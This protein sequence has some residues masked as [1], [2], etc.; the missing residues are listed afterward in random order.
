M[1]AVTL[2]ELEAA[3]L[4]VDDLEDIVNGASDLN[5]TGLVGTRT[6]GDKKTLSKI[7][8]EIAETGV[9]P[10]PSWSALA[11]RVPGL[12]YGVADIPK[13]VVGTHTD[14]VV[15]GTVD[16]A[17]RYYWS[18][19]PA[20]WERIGDAPLSAS[21]VSA[22]EADV[23]AVELSL[24]A[25]GAGTKAFLMAHNC[26]IIECAADGTVG[27]FR[28]VR[29][30]TQNRGA[31]VHPVYQGDLTY[32]EDVTD[33]DTGVSISTSPVYGEIWLRMGQSLADGQNGNAGA[34]QV[35]NGV[36]PEPLH[37]FMPA[38]GIRVE[39]ST[40][41]TTVAAMLETSVSNLGETGLTSFADHRIS[42]VYAETGIKPFIYGAVSANG[43]E[44]GL[45]LVRGTDDYTWAMNAIAD[46]AAVI[47]KDGRRPIVKGILWNH[48]HSEQAKFTSW[49]LYF[50]FLRTLIMQ[51]N[52]DVQLMLPG[53][54]PVRLYW[55]PPDAGVLGNPHGTTRQIDIVQAF[56][57]ASLRCDLIRLTGPIHQFERT[58]DE[59]HCT[60]KGYTL[61]GQMEARATV[62]DDSGGHVPVQW[63][64]E[65]CRWVGAGGTTLRMRFHIKN[66]PISLGA[67]GDVT[68]T[69]L[70]TLGY[71]FWDTTNSSTITPS[72]VSVVTPAAGAAYA[73]EIDIEF[74]TSMVG[75]AGF[76]MYGM[77]MDAGA[78]DHNNGPEFG[79]R[80]PIRDSLGEAGLAVGVGYD[81]DDLTIHLDYNFA[82]SEFMYVGAPV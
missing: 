19:S 40:R 31:T 9:T 66:R 82:I 64:R 3:K 76:I 18:V 65:Q 23:A 34:D 16:D 45:N 73:D 8:E 70:S 42:K 41:F 33:A 39:S 30:A 13:S 69:T 59:L 46:L 22:L 48:G 53:N 1:T 71:L 60:N 68:A 38:G 50:A 75:K 36:A 10:F 77:R 81:E 49:V 17:G 43:G 26:E 80:G 25:V 55:T 27:N 44:P 20:G 4:D 67:G 37:A 5:G 14:P 54:P 28:T 24:G 35:F 6:G 74:S 47:W 72:G 58:V 78:S 79:G 51:I 29:G 2:A 63:M 57:E 62:Q 12:G 7:M 21:D 32:D 56:A 61:I 15:G 11:A 52:E